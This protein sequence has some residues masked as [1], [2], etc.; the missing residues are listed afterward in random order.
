MPPR[1]GRRTKA[2]DEN[3]CVNLPVKDAVLDT[4][5]DRKV[6]ADRNA[7]L[8]NMLAALT[9]KL[10]KVEL[11]KDAAD[12]KSAVLQK[13]VQ[14]LKKTKGFTPT[15]AGVAVVQA[16]P[17][18]AKEG[19][20][21]KNNKPKENKPKQGVSTYLY[22]C[23]AMR[24]QV[25]VE[26]PDADFATTQKVLG[27]KWKGADDAAKAPFEV[28][29]AED[30]KRYQA[31]MVKYNKEQDSKKEEEKAL[32]MLHEKQEQELAMELLKQYQAHLKE[33]EET[34]PAGK[35]KKEVDPNKPKRNLN[36]YMFYHAER[37][38]QEQKNGDSKLGVAELS[39]TV[40]EEW[41]KLT[42]AKKKKYEKM[43]EKDHGRF[44]KEMEGY[45]AKK[46]VEEEESQAAASEK[47]DLD[48][49]EG[50]KLLNQQKTADEASKLLKGVKKA[51]QET[52]KFDR[53]EKAARKAA[54]AGQP[55]RP[56]S[57]Y[58]LFCNETRE[59]TKTANPET[60]MVD[61]QKILAENWKKVSEDEKARLQSQADVFGAEYKVQMAAWH[62]AHDGS[63][64]SEAPDDGD[65]SMSTV[66]ASMSTISA[67]RNLE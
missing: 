11:G 13:Q 35:I 22:F 41:H 55:K 21:T 34:V 50:K 38:M 56:P 9:D 26:Y 45:S 24:E 48:K 1:S 43:A 46:Q 15:L 64:M 66:S 5:P 25:K 65:D 19:A 10:Q 44:K 6:L 40:G 4:A 31:E 17:Q 59:A 39:K 42:G 8:E 60:P 67:N 36:A 32:N 20:K 63:A 14:S 30:T 23:N 29:A 61:I 49:V 58:L 16:E 57:A 51:E 33:A 3:A 7:D 28:M 53:A 18:P 54:R 52:R 47:A 62:E 12:K 2:V 27:E 37:R